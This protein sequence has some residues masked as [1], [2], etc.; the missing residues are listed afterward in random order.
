[1]AKL[2][3]KDIAPDVLEPLEPTEEEFYNLDKY[4]I[5][6]ER[7]GLHRNGIALIKPPQKWI[8]E[9]A[10]KENVESLTR[11]QVE[12]PSAQRTVEKNGIFNT[13]R[14][15]VNPMTVCEYFALAKT[16]KYKVYHKLLEFLIKFMFSNIC[17]ME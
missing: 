8:E 7:E 10:P 13:V 17:I 2:N 6:K 3:W 1:M 14:E 9:K 5:Q 15:D 12:W 11:F 16:D 4:L